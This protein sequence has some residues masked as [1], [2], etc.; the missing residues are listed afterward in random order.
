MPGT[1]YSVSGSI[2]SSAFL[3]AFNDASYVGPNVS[4]NGRDDAG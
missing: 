4:R 2:A 1:W 3:L